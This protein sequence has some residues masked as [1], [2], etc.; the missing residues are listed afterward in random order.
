MKKIILLLAVMT[1]I[2][3]TAQT[4]SEL[5]KHFETY[6]KQMQVQGDAQGV[7]NAMTH[8]Q[9]LQPSQARLDTL[10]YVYVS[11]GRNVEAL[12]TIGIE[13]NPNDSDIN[14]EV[15]AIALKA[16]NQPKRAVV[17]YEELFKRN[18]NPYIAYEIADLKTQLQDLSGAKASVDYGLANVKPDMKRG[19][20][21]SQRPYEV[22][23]K[24]ALTYMKALVVF[25]MNQTDNLDQAIN[26]LNE[27]I[28]MDANF[29]LAKLS[30]DA[31]EARKTGANKD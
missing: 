22:S 5:L 11:E 25:N 1:T 31:L 10:A 24:G 9:A 2:G 19:Y 21:E 23:L 8:L 15:K 26:L 14:T 17:F 16:V 29:N 13:Q 30:K 20:Y 18:A 7:I 27:V 3:A 12:N 4:K 6:Y 28:T